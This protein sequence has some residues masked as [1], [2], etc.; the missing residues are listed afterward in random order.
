MMF[1]VFANGML[2]ASKK[3]KGF[4]TKTF[5]SLKSERLFL[6]KHV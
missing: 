6:S 3:K 4:S 5:F 1:D 2:W